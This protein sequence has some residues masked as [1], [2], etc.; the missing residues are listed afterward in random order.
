MQFSF[1]VSMFIVAKKSVMIP[2]GQSESEHR[3]TDNT[4]TKRIWNVYNKFL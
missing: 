1:I 2:K 4:M 3:R